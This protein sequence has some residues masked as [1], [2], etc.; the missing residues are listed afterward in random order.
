MS[1]IR[2]AFL[3]TPEI[4]KKCLESLIRDEHFE[5]VGVASQPDRPAGRKMKLT[6][7][8]VKELALSLG[9]PMISPESINTPE[10]LAEVASWRA[11]VA[12]VVAFGQIVSQKFLD[13]FPA[14]VV[15]LHASLLPKWRGAAPV[16]RALM[17]GDLETGVALQIMVK[18]LDAGPILGARKI[19]IPS[20]MNSNEL[21]SEVIRMGSDLLEVDLMDYLR[22]NLV[23]HAQDESQASYASK[24]LKEEA[25]IDW[26]HDAWSIHNRVRGLASGPQAFTHRQGKLLKIHRTQVV[27]HIPSSLKIGELYSVGDELF[28]GTS[29]GVLQL[30]ELQPESKSSMKTAEYLRGHPV[31]KGES[32]EF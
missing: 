16:Q 26:S 6:P 9:I 2:T 11:E 31:Q 10:S 22:G 32:F 28:V 14:K 12:V 3:G 18:K 17:N 25:K 13:L 1:R 19:Q 8:P 4:A 5:V 24:I 29:L 23:P 27:D 21:F 7:S 30:L 20:S 15:N